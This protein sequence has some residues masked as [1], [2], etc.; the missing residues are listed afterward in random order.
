MCNLPKKTYQVLAEYDPKV[1]DIHLTK[2]ETRCIQLFKKGDVFEPKTIIN[3]NLDYLTPTDSTSKLFTTRTCVF[4]TLKIAKGL[5]IIQEIHD[6]PIS[7]N[8]FCEQESISYFAD[9]LRGS[10]NRNLKEN[11][12][13]VSTKRDYLYRCWEFNNWLHGQSFDFKVVKHL[14]ES[15][16]EV[17]TETVTLDGL[18][19]LLTL[20]KASFNSESDYI[21][22]IKRFLNSESNAKCSAGYMHMKRTAITSYFEKNECEL[23][24]KYDPKVKHHDTIESSADATLSL[25]DLLNMLTSGRASILDK[26]V[27]LCKFHRGL[28]NTTFADRFNFVVYDQ[29]VEYFGHTDYE[30]WDITKCPV[31]IKLTRIKTNYT[32][33]GFLDVDAIQAIQKYLK[34]RY[35][36]TGKNMQTGDAM[37]LNRRLEP[38]TITWI[39]DLIPKLARNAGIQKKL[40]GSQLIIRNEKT[41]HELR[42]LLKSTLI[43][44]GVAPYVCDLAIGHKVGDSYEKQDK[45]YPNNSRI[46]YAKASSQINIFSNITQ[47]MGENSEIAYYKKQVNDN[48]NVVSGLVT[49]L[50][51]VKDSKGDMYQMILDLR[52]EVNELRKNQK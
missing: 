5:G 10:K 36:K 41:S 50:Q 32:H 38:I 35:E 45:L 42:D 34:V 40:G 29:L 30:N 46:E 33:R 4:K 22:I 16:F 43:V 47:N 21:K 8:D 39:S 1:H 31:P 17:K 37:F 7:F 20:Y 51:D 44:N 14:S 13:L 3:D 15:T 23:K 48:Q 49:D 26:A 27:V 9:Q 6:E 11:R 12:K 28:D 18:E 2:K 19:H 52:N 25:E 24:F